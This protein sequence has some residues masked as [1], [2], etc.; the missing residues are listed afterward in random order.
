MSDVGACRGHAVVMQ[1]G[2]GPG[3]QVAIDTVIGNDQETDFLQRPV[4]RWCQ[5]PSAGEPV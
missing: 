5:L 2:E 1:P 3:D 4:Q